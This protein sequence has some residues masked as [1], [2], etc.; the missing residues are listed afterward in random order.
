MT[1]DDKY[2]GA[3]FSQTRGGYRNKPVT[4]QGWLALIIYVIALGGSLALL[5]WG[6]LA[7]VAAFVLISAIFAFVAISKSR[8][9][10]NRRLVRR[11]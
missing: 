5:R 10:P 8:P 9:N 7:F 2:G 3:W 1:S 4:W 11:D 6:E